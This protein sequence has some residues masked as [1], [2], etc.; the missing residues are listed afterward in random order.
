VLLAASAR[1]A[2]DLG[3]LGDLQGI[4]DF[5]AKVSDCTFEPIAGW[6]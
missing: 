1:H 3:L 6:Q 2:S 4:I 5:D